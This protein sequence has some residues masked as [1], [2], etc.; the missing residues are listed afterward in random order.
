MRR[1]LA[2]V[3]L[4]FLAYAPAA[5]GGGFDIPDHGTE[6]LGRGGAF[7]AKADDGTAIEYNI[8]GFARQRGTR[9]TLDA[10]A[11]IHG[12]SFR[13]SGVYSGDAADSRTPY[14]GLSYPTIHDR[15][16]YFLSPIL[17]ISTDFGWFKRWTFAFGIYGPPAI[18]KHT[19]TEKNPSGDIPATVTLPG[20]LRAPGPARYDV[21]K[22]NVLILLPTWAVAVR[23]LKWLDAG[24]AAQLVYANFDLTS[25]NITPLGSGTCPVADYAGCD[26]YA[27]VSTTG[28][29]FAF[30]VSLLAHPTEWLDVGAT[31]RSPIDID[32]S[33]TLHPTAPPGQF[34]L[35]DSPVTFSTKLPLWLRTGIRGV[36]RYPDGTERADLEADFVYENWGA[37]KSDHIYSPDFLLGKG[38]VLDAHVV[39]NY[40]DTFGVR[41]GGAY[42]FRLGNWT[43]LITR[44]GFYFDSAAT[45]AAYTR[46]D[47]NTAEKY[48]FTAGLGFKWKGLTI[49]AAYAYVFT[50]SRS[51]SDSEIYAL[52]ATN[53]NPVPGVDPMIAVGNGRYSWMTQ[54][55]SLGI[56]VNTGEFK[57]AK[58]MPN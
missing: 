47:F 58:L 43:R 18:G 42:N 38:G 33:G 52:S 35:K 41:V 29:S 40:K 32:S 44:L 16:S 19:F 10:N 9:I 22:L 14:G 25:A 36:L 3:A 12:T 50:P 8:A 15:E 51:V 37:E 26:A 30:L 53:G 45:D 5:R 7:V 46:L 13:R 6:A 20:G 48:G 54:I 11:Y 27:Q 23:P 24:L 28:Y 39:H 1:K 56:T 31:F 57:S 2:G 49:N 34:D 21:A 17:T 55:V 4:F